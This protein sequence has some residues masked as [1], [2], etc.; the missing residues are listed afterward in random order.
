[1]KKLGYT[2]G[3][4][5]AAIIDTFLFHTW[6]LQTMALLTIQLKK[7]TSTMFILSPQELLD[8]CHSLLSALVSHKRLVTTP[9]PPQISNEQQNTVSLGRCSDDNKFAGNC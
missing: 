9:A 1:M 5:S 8:S 3:F 6:I 2:P 7:F 4:G